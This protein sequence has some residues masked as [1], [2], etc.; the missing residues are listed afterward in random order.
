MSDLYSVPEYNL[1]ATTLF[2]EADKTDIDKF[3]QDATGIA[4]VLKNRVG[5]PER[6]GGTYHDVILS[7]KQFSAVGG[8]EWEKALTNNLTEDEQLFMKKAL[9]ISGRLLKGELENTVGTADHY[10][11][12]K[13]ASPSWGKS[14]EETHKT[15][16]HRFLSEISSKEVKAN[17]TAAL[18]AKLKELGY[19]VGKIDGISGKMTKSAVKSFQKDNNLKVDGVAGKNTLAALGL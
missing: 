16:G 4:N 7:P 1:I 9:Q 3:E 6:F 8:N 15:S 14:Y 12:P 17:Q 10:Y 18:Q 19:D 2:S 13:L 5:R 11:N